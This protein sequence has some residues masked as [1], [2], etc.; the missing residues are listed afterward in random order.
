MRVVFRTNNRG[1]A[2]GAMCT[3]ECFEPSTAAPVT[4]QQLVEDCACG[5]TKD[6]RIVGG[7]ETEINKYPWMV[8]LSN[9]GGGQ[10]C[11]GSLLASKFVLTAAHCLE[12]KR[13]EGIVAVIG[14]HD[15]YSSGETEL[16]TRFHD[17]AKIILHEAYDFPANDIA[18]VVLEE[19]V[20][21]TIYNT[22]C[23]PLPGAKFDGEDALVTGWG[24]LEYDT[25]N[26]PDT[27]Q[28]VYLPV[29]TDDVCLDHVSEAEDGGIIC[30]GG[31]LGKD[32]CQG[33]SGGPLSVDSGAGFVQIGVVSGGIGCGNGVNIGF[34]AEVSYYLDWLH[35]KMIYNGDIKVCTVDLEVAKKNKN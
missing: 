13:A 1:H 15:L 11:G 31:E 30:A 17:V 35:Q 10:F 25:G 27:L 29:Q 4:G 14:E 19:E 7:N 23:P 18:L 12:R 24:A 22:I 16:E 9:K 28:E 33:D 20:D 34:Y 5:A 8:A 26:Y 3:I 32:S 21:I 2:P 6:D